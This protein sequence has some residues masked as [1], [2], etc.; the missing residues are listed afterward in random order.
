MQRDSIKSR[1]VRGEAKVYR[2]RAAKT[3]VSQVSSMTE[4]EDPA[5]PSAKV[6]RAILPPAL[7]S[8]WTTHTVV[9]YERT[10]SFPL[11]SCNNSGPSLYMM[12][13]SCNSRYL[14]PLLP[15]VPKQ[16]RNRQGVLSWGHVSYWSLQCSAHFSPLW[17][18]IM[19]QLLSQETSPP[20]LALQ[21]EC[22]KD[23]R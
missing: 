8:V 17:P 16:Q 18:F 21:Q 10:S 23:S 14:H 12:Q 9:S 20:G 13:P 19:D 4:H 15:P 2:S 7:I 1:V 5:S 11:V 3:R 22:L 6:P